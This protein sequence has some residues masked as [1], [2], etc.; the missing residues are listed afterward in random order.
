MHK[1][2]SDQGVELAGSAVGVEENRHGQRSEPETEQEVL[3]AAD[4]WGRG[5]IVV[6][7]KALGHAP[8]QV[9]E[10]GKAPKGK[11]HT[12]GPAAGR[13]DGRDQ[14]DAQREL[15][16]VGEERAGGFRP[17]RNHDQHV[18]SATTRRQQL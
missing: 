17:K 1:V 2:E 12:L 13:D 10:S 18:S 7:A 6:N 5:D 11:R 4:C 3:N 16:Q 14:D 9:G 8:H 15:N